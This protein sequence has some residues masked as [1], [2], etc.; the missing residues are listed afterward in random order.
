MQWQTGTVSDQHPELSGYEPYADKPLRSTRKTLLLRA[1]VLLAIIGLVLPGVVTTITVGA[2][3]AERACDYRGSILYPQSQEFD[4]R[5]EVFGPGIL[6][7]ECYLVDPFDGEQHVDSMG[8]I[9]VAPRAVEP[10][11]QGA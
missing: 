1:I 10:P 6:G 2:S 9:P 7:W 4:A 11:T 8:L 3:N 5:F